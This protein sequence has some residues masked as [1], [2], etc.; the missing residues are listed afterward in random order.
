M[1]DAILNYNGKA[2]SV[3]LGRTLA[4]CI[5]AERPCNGHGR[6]GKCKVVATGALSP[7]DDSE[8][9][10]LSAAE[11]KDN[12]RL[13][14]RARVLGDCTV[15]PYNKPEQAAVLIDGRQKKT[16]V[17]PRFQRYGVALDIGTTTLAARLYDKVGCVL[18]ACG[19]LNPQNRFGA[20]VISRIE[21]SLGGKAKELSLL[22]LNSID[23]MLR[24]LAIA[25]GTNVA[26]IDFL[27]L[28]GNTAMFYLLTASDPTALSK[29][30]FRADRLFG[31]T[32]NAASLGISALPDDATVLLSPCIS[33]FVG[34]DTT[35]ALLA[36]GLCDRKESAMLV[37]IGTNGEIAL[38]HENALTVCSTAAGPAFEGAGITMGMRGA[39]GA[40]D[41]VQLINGRLEAHVIGDASPVGI[42]GSGLVDAV[43]CLLDAEELDESGY[44]DANKVT[45]KGDVCLFDKDIRMLQLAKSAICAGIETTMQHEGVSAEQIGTLYIAGGFGN[46]LHPQSAARIGLLPRALCHKIQSKGNAALDGAAMLLLDGSLLSKARSLAE[47]ATTLELSTSPVFSE[48]YMSG[49]LL[50]EI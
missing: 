33:A 31:E 34:A 41:R 43:A 30:P 7:I 23:E 18:S 24:E 5:G 8:R 9:A 17:S 32:V 1:S 10:H 14:C 3:S 2:F 42:C 50:Q 29:A 35:C 44:L 11:L 36:T 21:A 19:R 13:S 38:W 22:I 4:E 12:V 46:Y 26:E 20:D 25:A 47:T 15:T 6:C 49:M 28:T 37:D 27:C 40:I 16:A 48:L 45:V 39:P